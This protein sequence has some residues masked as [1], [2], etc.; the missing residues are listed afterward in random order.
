MSREKQVTQLH[1]T[2]LRA[3]NPENWRLI[4]ELGSRRHKCVVQIRSQGKA[5]DTQI[6]R[7]HPS[8]CIS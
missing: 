4:R 1:A 5:G 7:L 2:G 8:A 6:L 3:K